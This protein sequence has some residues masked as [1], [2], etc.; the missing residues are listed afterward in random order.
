M[1]NPFLRSGI[2]L[3]GAN[4]L[5]RGDLDERPD[6]GLAMAMEV[7]GMDLR[8]TD[9]MVLSACYTGV[10]KIRRKKTRFSNI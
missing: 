4:R 9:L 3:S 10:V 7:S 8:N 1:E 6:D 5:G 2:A